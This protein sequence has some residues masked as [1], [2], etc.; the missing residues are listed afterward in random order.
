MANVWKDPIFDR[1][2]EDVETAIQKIAGWKK[3]HTHYIDVRVENDALSLQG[4]G[5]AYVTDTALVMQ[6]EGSMY[7]EDG[8]V[9][10][11]IDDHQ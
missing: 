11:D 4:R 9:I 8:E 2:L 3:G 6:H 7:I 1:T 10:L 5:T